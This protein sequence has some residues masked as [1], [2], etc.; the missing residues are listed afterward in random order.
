MTN[1]ENAEVKS[2]IIIDIG[3]LDDLLC[4]ETNRLKTVINDDGISII[5]S[6][7]AEDE[8]V[9][10]DRSG[11]EI[12]TKIFDVNVTSYHNAADFPC[13]VYVMFKG[14]NDNV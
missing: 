2:C 5:D 13:T 6:E 9:Y 7:E 14:D 11:I 1:I 4:K 3:E 12:L 10:D 8:G